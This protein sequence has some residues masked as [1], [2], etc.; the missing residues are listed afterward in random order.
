MFVLQIHCRLIPARLGSFSIVHARYRYHHFN[1]LP[2]K[3]ASRQTADTRMQNQEERACT[4]SGCRAP[5]PASGA[6]RC[7][8]RAPLVDV[9][10]SVSHGRFPTVR[11]KPF[12]PAKQRSEQRIL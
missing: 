7:E 9:R 10:P 6:E 12:S 3:T 11:V 5:Q 8:T 2:S 4:G 1:K